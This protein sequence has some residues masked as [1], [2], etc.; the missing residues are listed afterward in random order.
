MNYH[1]IETDEDGATCIGHGLIAM[2]RQ[3]DHAANLEPNRTYVIPKDAIVPVPAD[4]RLVTDEEKAKYAKPTL[5]ELQVYR[6]GEW[7]V[8][9][10]SGEWGE[11]AYTAPKDHIWAE[12]AEDCHTPEPWGTALFEHI[13]DEHGLTLTQTEMYEIVRISREVELEEGN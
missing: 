6:G 12:D 10:G 9:C 11:A 8:V 4:R 2:S 1:T 7:D 3:F 13:A 5:G